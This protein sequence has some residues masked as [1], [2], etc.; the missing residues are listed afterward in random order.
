MPAPRRRSPVEPDAPDLPPEPR[1]VTELGQDVRTVELSEARVERVVATGARLS[2][3]DLVDC[4]VVA[5][6]LAGLRAP[7]SRLRRVAVTGGR[8]SGAQLGDCELLDVVVRDCRV[9]LVSLRRARLERVRFEHCDLRE[10]DL[11]ELRADAVVFVGCDLS[12]AA[13]TGARLRRAEL[14]GCTLDGLE[15]VEALRGVSMPYADALGA[16]EVLARALGIRLTA[17]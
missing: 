4:E 17:D 14:R 15:G 16:V 5:C 7:G 10:A 11:A 1:V 12:G 13:F 8:F 3:A 2:R 6:D 9:D